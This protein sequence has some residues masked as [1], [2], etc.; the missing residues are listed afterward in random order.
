MLGTGISITS[1][2]T[3]GGGA[4]GGVPTRLFAPAFPETALSMTTAIQPATAL[5]WSGD[6]Y[7]TPIDR[8]TS[9]V[10]AADFNALDVSLDAYIWD[11]GGSGFGAY[12]GIRETPLGSGIKRLVLRFGDGAAEVVA[13]NPGQ[14]WS[15]GTVYGI[16]DLAPII[17]DGGTGTLTWAAHG[18]DGAAA[19][20]RVW[21][22]GVELAAEYWQDAF[23]SDLGGSDHGSYLGT[24]G[25]AIPIGEVAAATRIAGYS[26]VSALRY[27]ED[28]EAPPEFTAG[29]ID[30][31]DGQSNGLSNGETFPGSPVFPANAYQLGRYDGNDLKIITAA[32]PLHHWERTAD[33]IGFATSYAVARARRD[34]A[35]NR[36][37]IPGNEG[38]SALDSAGWLYNGSTIE[39]SPRL[40]RNS[41]KRANYVALRNP[42]LTMGSILW[43][44]GER[45]VVQG[46]TKIEHAA[47]LDLTLTGA[48]THIIPAGPTTPI[49]VVGLAP[50]YVAHHDGL[51]AGSG[52]A[53]QE[54]LAETP[55]R[56]AYTMFVPTDDL[57]TQDAYTHFDGE[58]MEVIGLR[59]DHARVLAEANTTGTAA[60]AYTAPDQVEELAAVAG[61]G[62]V[63][64]TWGLRFDGNRSITGHLIERN[65][66]G[67]WATLDAAATAA[68]TY[69]DATAVN[70]TTY[71]YRVSA[72]NPIGTGTASAEVSATPEGATVSPEVG[73]IIHTLFGTDNA[74]DA[75]LVSGQVPDATAGL[76]RGTGYIRLT[77]QDAYLDTGIADAAVQTYACVVRYNTLSGNMAA[78]GNYR[79]LTDAGTQI[80][81]NGTNVRTIIGDSTSPL[82]S[83]SF[84]AGEWHFMAVSCGVSSTLVYHVD[85]TGAQ[86]KTF[87][88]R[89]GL[90][91]ANILL[92]DDGAVPLFAAADTDIAEMMIFDSAKSHAEMADIYT[93][94]A[95]RMT[96]RG[97]TIE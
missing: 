11:L 21:W 65:D 8:G 53:I 49:M 70:G 47:R 23:R 52:T 81:Y 39:G 33:R 61:D 90:G 87:A 54:A 86:Q 34:P 78:M 26:A 3:R 29:E 17:A 24:N 59:A 57:T 45:S 42:A 77:G 27:F 5:D 30:A 48:R 22:N 94:T 32:D 20:A 14:R 68:R 37:F 7:A 95:A 88:V 96:A 83:G 73:A 1:L 18:I 44:Q 12:L 82:G 72:I 28:Q 35:L 80:Y 69:T 46:L 93:R 62:S 67:G 85:A 50:A 31:L 63:A 15:A 76:T 79:G 55:S 19:A 2:A 10:W 41:V 92:G 9:S 58:S 16:Y 74:T 43:D 89:G 84:T 51:V 4:G 40:F 66:G 38:G 71:D 6:G 56:L 25:G 36:V 75:D 97:I 60:A 13:T 91:V 64:L